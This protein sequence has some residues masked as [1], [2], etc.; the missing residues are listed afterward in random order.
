[1]CTR[2]FM[3]VYHNT[4]NNQRGVLDLHAKT[5]DEVRDYVHGNKIYWA[6]ACLSIP[7]SWPILK[8]EEKIWT[9]TDFINGEC[10]SL[11]NN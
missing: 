3:V 10:W 1:M 5:I 7:K 6:D 8:I 11:L 4:T 2:Y 9:G